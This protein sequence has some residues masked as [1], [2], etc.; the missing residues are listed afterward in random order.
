MFFLTSEEVKDLK[1]SVFKFGKFPE[2]NPCVVILK[3]KQETEYIYCKKEEEEENQ[4]M[5]ENTQMES[6]S[7][8]EL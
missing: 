5:Q 7:D 6:I 2:H 1:Y 3:Y 4:E 8:I